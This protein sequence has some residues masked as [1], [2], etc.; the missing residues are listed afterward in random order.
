MYTPTN[1]TA[2]NQA[3][4][5]AFMQRYS[6]AT[7]VTADAG[8]PV[9]T[10]LPLVVSV[11][12]EQIRISGHFAK[13]NMQWQQLEKAKQVLMIFNEPHAYISPRHYDKEQSVPT[14]N[15]FAVHAYGSARLITDEAQGFAVLNDMIQTYEP[16]YQAQ[17]DL[18]P[19][20]YKLKMLNGIVPFVI[21]V[22]D[23]Q[24]SKKLSQNRSD[25][26]KQRIITSLAASD[27]SNERAIAAYMKDN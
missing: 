2:Q 23:L 24:A 17:W 3:E 7:V 10:H 22:D 11:Q 14:W 4:L 9:A 8:L 5:I 16:E 19:D 26:E 13:A 12:N 20:A 1:Y 6:F 25:T 21:V 27:D 18:L 15:Y